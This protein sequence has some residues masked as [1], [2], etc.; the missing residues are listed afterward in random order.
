MLAYVQWRFWR[1]RP[2]TGQL[3]GEFLIGYGM[4]RILG[5]IFREPDA[6]LVIGL[7]RGQFYSLFIILSGAITIW[8]VK[9]RRQCS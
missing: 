5:E 7:S 4:V 6:D 8:I 3:S 9:R 1:R 2:S